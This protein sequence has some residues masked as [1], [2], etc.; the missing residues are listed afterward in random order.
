[1]KHEDCHECWGCVCVCVCVRGL[2]SV[3]D[4]IAESAAG[5]TGDKRRKFFWG[6]K[7]LVQTLGYDAVE[8]DRNFR[9]FGSLYSIL[10]QGMS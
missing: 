5:E 8:I 4:T 7:F 6:L 9:S 1:M 2:F 10:L 3:S